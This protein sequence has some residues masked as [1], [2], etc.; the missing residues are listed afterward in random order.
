MSKF[1]NLVCTIFCSSVACNKYWFLLKKKFIYRLIPASS[2]RKPHVFKKWCAAGGR[3][4][5][6]V[7][8]EER[9]KKEY[10]QACTSWDCNLN[11]TCAAYV[12]FNVEE[13]DKD[14]LNHDAT[15]REFI[16]LIKIL[17]E[18]NDPATYT[19]KE[20]LIRAISYGEQIIMTEINLRTKN[21]ALI[22][23]HCCKTWFCKCCEIF[24]FKRSRKRTFYKWISYTAFLSS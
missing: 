9:W 1:D 22:T 3:L 14:L 13:D 24:N 18:N 19:I 10:I 7:W 5:V 4:V 8:N 15:K 16:A 6:R 11:M 12:V 20:N 17:D 21:G 2:I 23:F